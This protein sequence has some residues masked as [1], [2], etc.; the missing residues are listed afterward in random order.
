MTGWLSQGPA[1]PPTGYPG[2]TFT[3]PFSSPHQ[4][5]I[6]NHSLYYLFLVINIYTMKKGG[7]WF[8]IFRYWHCNWNIFV[9]INFANNYW[10]NVWL[11][12]WFY[13]TFAFWLISEVWHISSSRTS[14]ET[15]VLSLLGCI[16]IIFATDNLKKI[17]QNCFS[18]FD[19]C[20]HIKTRT[21]KLAVCIRKKRKKNLFCHTPRR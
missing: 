21:F 3:N 13:L 9:F 16:V 5:L 12:I 1:V 17:I 15:E 20:I 4:C 14:F 11:Y 19:A 2:T 18:Y 7:C 8:S 10:N 6:S